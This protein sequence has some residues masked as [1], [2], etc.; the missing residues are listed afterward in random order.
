[1]KLGWEPTKWLVKKAKLGFRGYPIGTIAFYGP[2][3]RRASKAVTCIVTA[4]GTDPAEIKKWFAGHTDVRHDGTIG[5]EIAAFLRRN[6]VRSV[7]M[8]DG[9]IGCPHEEGIDYPEGGSCPECPFWKDRDRF[10]GEKI[11]VSKG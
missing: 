1:M 10:T 8:V 7:T 5:A 9:I 3:D 4:E 11:N 6:E 2:D